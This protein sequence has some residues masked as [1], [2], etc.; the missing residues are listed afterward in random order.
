MH[1]EAKTFEE[2]HKNSE[3]S[4]DKIENDKKMFSFKLVAAADF[5]IASVTGF[6]KIM[7]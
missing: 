1:S 6:N 3:E 4:R 7:T 5:L 2:K